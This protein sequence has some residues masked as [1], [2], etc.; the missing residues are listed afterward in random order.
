M[1]LPD[2]YRFT[3]AQEYALLRDLRKILECGDEI[4]FM[5]ILRK[6]GIKDEDERFAQLVRFFRGLRSGKT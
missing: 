3:K 1:A 5:R 4:E 2:K 6:H